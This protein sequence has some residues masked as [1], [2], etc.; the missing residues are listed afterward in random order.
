MA[1]MIGKTHDVEVGGRRC[2][3]C[4]PAPKHHRR[5]NRTAKRR[6]R[7]EWKRGVFAG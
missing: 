6:E 2:V 5:M 7:Q 3:C 4:Y 1:R